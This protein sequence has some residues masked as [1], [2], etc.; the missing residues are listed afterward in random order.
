MEFIQRVLIVD[1]EVINLKILSELVSEEAN[2]T[3]AKSGEQALRKAQQYQPDLILLDVKMPGLDGFET[4]SELRQNPL[5]SHIPVIFIS[6][7]A[8]Y[9]NEEKG[10]IHGAADYI[11]KPFHFGI[12]K[13]R[14]RTH[15]QLVEQTNR[16]EQLARR[17]YLT[18]LPNRRHYDEVLK[19]EWKCSQEARKYISLAVFD[20]DDF[21]L[22]ND[23]HGHDVGDELLKKVSKVLR[24]Y[25]SEQGYLVSRFGGE[26]FVVLMPGVNRAEALEQI[27]G[28]LTAVVEKSEVTMSAGGAS[29]IPDIRSSDSALFHLADKALYSAKAQGKNCV[30]WAD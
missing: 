7:L 19:S 1:D 29:C 10:L 30:V 3:L 27:M 9:N 17:D 15:L 12:V 22:F 23:L 13:A 18:S 24:E 28:C 20:I 16:L 21:K 6:A 11:F 4:L 5:T 14:V 26:E 8:D 2:V 25:F